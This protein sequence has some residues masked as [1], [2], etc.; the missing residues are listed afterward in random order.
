MSYF[1]NC[2]DR[3]IV[4]EEQRHKVDLPLIDDGCRMVGL[5]GHSLAFS[6]FNGEVAYK[7]VFSILASMV[8]CEK[9]GTVKQNVR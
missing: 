6:V 5:V 7:L 2:L 8:L 9:S 4:T 3:H 1:R